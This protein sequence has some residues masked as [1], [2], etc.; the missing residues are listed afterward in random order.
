MKFGMEFDMVFGIEV[1][2]LEIGTECGNPNNFVHNGFPY[3][4]AIILA[5]H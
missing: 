2:L 1:A 3:R 4:A 5:G